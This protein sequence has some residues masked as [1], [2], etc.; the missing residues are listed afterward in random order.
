[1]IKKPDEAAILK[2]L[3]DFQR[4]TV[5]YVFQQLYLEKT[6][7][8]FLIADEVGLG[9]T[10][11]AKGVLVKAINYLW[12]KVDRIDVLYIC[13]N[14]DIAHQNINK[15][16]ITADPELEHTSRITLLPLQLNGLKDKKLNFISFTP[17]TSFN[18]RSQGG[19]ALERALIY[20]MLK[21]GWGFRERSGAKNLFQCGKAKDNWRNDLRRFNPGRID[22]EI[23]ASFLHALEGKPELRRRFDDLVERFGHYR[24]FFAPEDRRDRDRFIGELRSILAEVCIKKLD[25][26]WLSSMN[27]NASKPCLMVK[28]RWQSSP[29]SSLI[30]LA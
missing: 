10:L 26:T 27:F 2:G 6:T 12:D 22:Q 11:V 24:K 28:T 1:M 4:N 8:R 23:K 5:D 21:E 13:S 29:N 3:K 16:N 15:L 9:K 18:L 17:G 30:I 20:H 19:V 25:R 14:A 7:A